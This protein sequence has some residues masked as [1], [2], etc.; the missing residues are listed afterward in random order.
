MWSDLAGNLSGPVARMAGDLLDWRDRRPQRVA[1][2]LTAPVA[3]T[4][5]LSFTEPHLRAQDALRTRFSEK[6]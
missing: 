4:I 5:L 6:R 1:T 3:V 2:G